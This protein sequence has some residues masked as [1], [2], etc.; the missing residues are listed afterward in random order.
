[1]HTQTIVLPSAR[2]IRHEQLALEEE[3]LFLPNYITMSEFISK[4]CIVPEYKHI[5]DDTRVLLLLE[6]SDFD[7]FTEL[8]IERNFFTFTKNSSYIFK[9]FQEISAEKYDIALLKNADIYGEYEEHISILIELYHRYE[10]LCMER[11]YLDMI[12][13]PS[14]Y[15]FHESYARSHEK[16]VIKVDG[17][18]TNFEFELLEKCSQCTEL[19]LLFSASRFNL[20]MQKKL[21][22]YGLDIEPNYSYE[23]DW[24]KHEVLRK[25]RY[26]KNSNITCS[27]FSEAL[28][29][30]AFVKSKIYEFISKGYAPE[31]IA[32]ILPNEARANMLRSFDGKANLNFAMVESYTTSAIY[33]KLH[34]TMELIELDSVENEARVERLGDELYIKLYSLYKKR[35]A[36]VDVLTFL[37][38]IGAEAAP[39]REREIYQEELHSFQAVIP[40]MQ[41]MSIQSL[42]K[43]FLQRLSQRSFDDIRGGKITVMGVLETRSLSFD[44]VI[45]LDFD[46]KSV[47]KKSDKDMFLNTFLRESA[48]LPTMHDRESLQKHYYDMLINSSKEVAIAYVN[49]QES[50]PSR[51]LK[52]LDVQEESLYEEAEYAKILFSRKQQN[53]YCFEDKIIPYSFKE[54]ELSATRLKIFLTCK[55]KYYLKYIAQIREHT[56]P[57]DMPQEHEIGTAV[58]LALKELYSKQSSYSDAAYLQKDL[59]REL[60]AICVKSEMEQYLIALQKKRLQKFTEQ[61]IE[62]FAQGYA[63]IA[64]ERGLKVEYGGMTLVGQIDRIDR[65]ADG[66]EVLDY[67]TGSY[68]L[69][70]KNSF[71]EA[72]DF[73][74]E[75]Y[76]ILAS[77]LGKV[78]RC[79]FYDLK[80]GTIV[81]E[82]FL[83]EKLAILE[84]HIK[85]LLSIESIDTKMCEDE[86][87]CLYCEYA[88]V[89][90][91]E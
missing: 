91:R 78:S 72:T 39:K 35:V 22:A 66:L 36:D 51:F 90:G 89:C 77:S 58:H 52:E 33:R 42:L 64:C 31:N 70:T 61:E 41:E 28:L 23:I 7:S 27:S 9:F 84:S 81:A 87:S 86:K 2:A 76:K 46:D 63:V 88:T 44:G 83:E 53:N 71:M 17:Y 37:E 65:G 48:G 49:S 25:K 60:D 18:L 21:N 57:A 4:L 6:A 50:A 12:F 16:I 56:I 10:S 34:A 54:V 29:E 24:N 59:E 79:G 47:P 5:D 1:M 32:V 68:K 45:I 69:Y 14:L 85:D 20:K 55:R 67:K 40:F 8:Q 75:F 3:T 19:I 80:E 38:E 13:L 62:R 43:L 82:P 30:V 73:Q 15:E 26:E 74:L 11:K